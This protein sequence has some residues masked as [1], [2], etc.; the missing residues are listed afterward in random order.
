MVWGGGGREEE[1]RKSIPPA[2]LSP[3]NQSD[4]W[5]CFA[6]NDLTSKRMKAPVLCYWQ[7]QDQAITWKFTW[8]VG[9]KL[10]K[11]TVATS[12]EWLG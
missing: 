3:N 9:W 7:K 10:V 6:T 4:Y 8:V 11:L 1:K 2:P 12:W 5:G